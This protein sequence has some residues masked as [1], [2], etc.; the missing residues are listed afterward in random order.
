[1]DLPD[2][3]LYINCGTFEYT[4]EKVYRL[5]AVKLDYEIDATTLHCESHFQDKDGTMKTEIDKYAMVKIDRCYKD[6]SAKQSIV[7]KSC[8]TQLRKTLAGTAKDTRGD[9]ER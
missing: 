1:L 6:M 8:L 2:T 7:V 3:Q 9:W 5:F 4:K